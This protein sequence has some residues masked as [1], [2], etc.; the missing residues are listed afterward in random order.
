MGM[1]RTIAISPEPLAI[2]GV[3]R[4]SFGFT[5][6]NNLEEKGAA[7]LNA[8]LREDSLYRTCEPL[9]LPGPAYNT[10]YVITMEH[11]AR[12]LGSRAPGPVDY[13]RYR[14]LQIYSV[15]TAQNDLYWMRRP[16]G[17]LLWAKL[18][19]T[20]RSWALY[21]GF[22][23]WRAKSGSVSQAK[24]IDAVGKK[25]EPYGFT[26]I[27]TKRAVGLFARLP[28]LFDALDAGTYPDPALP[29]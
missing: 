23:N 15:I 21:V 27:E 3:S 20:E 12:R 8:K 11:V 28:E 7:L 14:R 5:L 9:L 2:A 6:F 16:P 19:S 25:V 18:T 13:Q 4:A 1:G 26:A 24:S 10:N 17:S 22:L 29:A